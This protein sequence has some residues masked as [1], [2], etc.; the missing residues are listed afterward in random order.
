MTKLILGFSGVGKSTICNSDTTLNC[1]DSD[2]SKFGWVSENGRLVR[3]PNFAEEYVTYLKKQLLD[4][5]IDIVFASTHPEVIK[6]LQR[7]NIDHL[8]VTPSR[9]AKGEYIKRWKSR[10]SD[11][12][13][14][15]RMSENFEKFVEDVF[16]S[17]SNILVLQGKQTMEDAL[18]ILGES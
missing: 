8:I 13:F 9:S 7:Q 14:V 2:S 12:E 10:G 6:E 16:N 15:K 1:S 18:R 5:G 17:G 11:E 4:D 3:N